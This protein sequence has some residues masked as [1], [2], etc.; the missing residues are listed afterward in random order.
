MEGTTMSNVLTKKDLR[1]CLNRYIFTRQS[2][3]NYETMQSGGW[4]YSIHP[5]MEK[6]YDCDAD[7]LAE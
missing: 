5:A 2:P 6:I 4:V 1:R 3:F 7:L